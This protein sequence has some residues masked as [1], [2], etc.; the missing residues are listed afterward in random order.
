M[1]KIISR[2]YDKY[3]TVQ[4]NNSLVSNKSGIRYETQSTRIYHNLPKHFFDSTII[5]AWNSSPDDVVSVEST[6]NFISFLSQDLKF[7]GMPTLP[8]LEIVVWKYYGC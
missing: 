2:I 5:S 4:F 1:Y 7:D 8:E 6:N 3:T